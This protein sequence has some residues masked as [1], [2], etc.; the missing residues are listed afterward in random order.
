MGSCLS[1]NI[2]NLKKKESFNECDINNKIVQELLINKNLINELLTKINLNSYNSYS[3]INSPTNI[4]NITSLDDINNLN[5]I[6]DLNKITN[7]IPDLTNKINEDQ[8]IFNNELERIVR[9]QNKC[10][11]SLTDD[12]NNIFDSKIDQLN[13]LIE[14]YNIKLK[15]IEEKLNQNPI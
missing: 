14:E 3:D 11:R 7:K 4:K 13:I 1:K 15:E 5:D 6:P 12:I 9:L 10:I 8:I 2:D